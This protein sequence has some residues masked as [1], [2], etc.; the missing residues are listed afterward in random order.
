MHIGVICVLY[1]SNCKPFKNKT[2][3]GVCRLWNIDRNVNSFTFKNLK[4]FQFELIGSWSVNVLCC[5]IQIRDLQLSATNGEE[6]CSIR[7]T[8][9]RAM[10]EDKSLSNLRSPSA[11][12]A[13]SNCSCQHVVESLTSWQCFWRNFETKFFRRRGILFVAFVY[14]LWRRFV[15]RFTVFESSFNNGVS[16]NHNNFD[17]K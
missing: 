7:N 6:T 13:R 8:Q 15:E 12:S 5:E 9:V 4:K 11:D 3:M 2:S 17:N 16:L 1:L 10:K 14:L